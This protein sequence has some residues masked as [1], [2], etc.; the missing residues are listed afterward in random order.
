M[1][2]GFD[3][4]FLYESR[5]REND[6]LKQLEKSIQTPAP[7]GNPKTYC[8]D[9]DG[10][11]HYHETGSGPGPLTEPLDPGI[12]M[13]K[14][15]KAA[16]HK[17]VIL[18]ARPEEQHDDILGWLKGNGVKADEVTSVKPPAEAYIDDRAVP[19]P[20]NQRESFREGGPGS[21]P[22]SGQ[23]NKVKWKE[24]SGWKEELGDHGKIVTV[25]FS[26][27]KPMSPKFSLEDKDDQKRIAK[28]SNKMKQGSTFPMLEVVEE[29]GKL[30]VTDGN[31]RYYSLLKAGPPKKLPVLLIRESKR[32]AIESFGRSLREGGTG[33]GNFGH[34]GR[35]GE[36]G[37]AGPG[38]GEPKKERKRWKIG[39]KYGLGGQ[40]KGGFKVAMAKEM[41]GGRHYKDL[42]RHEK[43]QVKAALRNRGFIRPQGSSEANA[44]EKELLNAKVLKMEHLGGGINE[45]VL[46]TLE[47]G[48]KAVFKTSDMR[49]DAEREVGAWQVAKLVGLE[50]IVP[51]SV[52]RSIG[53]EKGVMMKFWDGKLAKSFKDDKEAYDG[54]QDLHRAA[55][56]DYVIGNTDRHMGNWLVGNGKLQLIDHGFSFGPYSGNFRIMDEVSKRENN[57][58]GSP[59]SLKDLGK[60]YVDNKDKILSALR[61]TGVPSDKVDEVGQRI[62]RISRKDNWQ[63]LLKHRGRWG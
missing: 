10:V 25:N 36:I 18:T 55:M 38:G 28:F 35:P 39:E 6:P 9:F 61:S 54:D 1:S 60:P 49:L 16:G 53:G 3:R 46:A 40:V 12:K 7:H 56:F 63:G 62:D 42:E 37:G 27:L 33:S 14:R 58:G 24:P 19:W 34:Q 41:F 5:L 20:R 45:T 44:G 43:N 23:G 21:G 52:V 57:K 11:L 48:I 22:R 51:P 32:K 17:L 50:D 13:A 15:I 31:T 30:L 4:D 8:V 59:Y 2:L 47:G 29:K 26:Q